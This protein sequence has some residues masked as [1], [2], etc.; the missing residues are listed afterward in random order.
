MIYVLDK[1]VSIM[2]R[3]NKYPEKIYDNIDR[4]LVLSVKIIHSY[5]RIRKNVKHIYFLILS[6]YDLRIIFLIL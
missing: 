5:N 6:M 3:M 2:F 1:K 4:I